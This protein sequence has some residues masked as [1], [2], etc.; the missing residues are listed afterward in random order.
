MDDATLTT[1]LCEIL[2]SLPGWAWH[3]G[4]DDPYTGDD[5]AVFYG[6][7]AEAPHRAV[8]IRTYGGTD[9]L[10]YGPQR[11]VQIRSR[12]MPD[13]PDGADDLAGLVLAVLQG[14]TG[15][16]ISHIARQNFGPLGADANRREERSDNYIITLDNQEVIS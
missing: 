3:P 15:R 11:R 8:G 16:G 5:V 12:G 14:Y 9:P 10:V 2:G 7:L 6:A 4:P 13:D 1:V